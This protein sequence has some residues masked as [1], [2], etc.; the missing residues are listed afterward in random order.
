MDV[1]DLTNK[2]AAVTGAASGI[3]RA[4][5][6]AFAL[7]G[8]QLAICD[9]DEAGLAET[10]ALAAA[11]GARVLARPVDVSSADEMR[12]FA[13]AVHA[14][15]GPLDLLMNNAGVGLGASFQDTSLADWEWI[16][17]VNLRGVIHGCH[18]FVPAMVERGR[19]GHVVN[20]SSMAGYLPSEL[21]SA[22]TTTKY[23]VL[24]LSESLRI[25]LARHRIG[26][27]A[28]CPGVID[29]NITRSTPLRGAA[30]AAD[31][32]EQMVG[33]YQRRGYG[34]E[35]VAEQLLKAIARNRA[36]APVT[37]EAWGFYYLKRLFPGLVHWISR[38]GG[39]RAPG[40]SASPGSGS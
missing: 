20:V 16:L 25:E 1:R 26:V 22:Y 4:S 34:P 7:R 5:A 30:D 14:E 39:E 33:A 28:L 18:F 23:A 37:P 3:G 24:G 35:R 10:E 21:L 15:T 19:G 11:I 38:K 8:A 32:R 9:R 6:L 36:I 29:T 17:G 27:T 13:E 2:V 12:G 40:S 31:A